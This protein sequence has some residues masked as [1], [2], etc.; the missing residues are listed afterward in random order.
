ML[1]SLLY[2]APVY[3]WEGQRIGDWDNWEGVLLLSC[4]SDFFALNMACILQL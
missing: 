3:F 4:Y 2:A 1:F